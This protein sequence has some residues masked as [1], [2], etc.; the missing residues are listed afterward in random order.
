MI[1]FFILLEGSHVGCHSIMAVSR[2]C[3]AEGLSRA[4]LAGSSL[5]G[6]P[7]QNKCYG[8]FAISPRHNTGDYNTCLSQEVP[9]AAFLVKVDPMSETCTACCQQWGPFHTTGGLKKQE[10]FGDR[11]RTLPEWS[12]FENAGLPGAVR[13][14]ETLAP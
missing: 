5:N 1:Q 11:K 9:S 14:G 6:S 8:P 12:F 10:G 13:T 2:L 3:C 4:E 7:N